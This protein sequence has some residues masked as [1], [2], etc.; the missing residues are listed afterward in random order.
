MGAA[1]N[2]AIQTGF[3]DSNPY[4]GITPG[5]VNIWAPD[6]Y[7]ASPYGYYLEALTEFYDVTGENPELFGANDL[8]ASEIGIDP[9]QATLLQEFAAGEPLLVP[10][11]ASAAA[12]AVGLLGLVWMR[13][14]R[15]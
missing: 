3:A 12:V 11:P 15:T 7:H 9:A 2:E 10:E 5:E 4:D 8:L 14:R 1:F 6:S 13:R